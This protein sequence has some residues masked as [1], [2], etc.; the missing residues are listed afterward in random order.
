MYEVGY[1]ACRAG[2]RR[3]GLS[4][5]TVLIFLAAANIAAANWQTTPSIAVG[6]LYDDNVRLNSDIP[7]LD[8][9]EDGYAVE[10]DV[11]FAFI[12]QLTSFSLTPKIAL[13]RFSGD[14]SL[15]STDEYVNFDLFRR[16]EKSRFR[17]RGGYS[18][19][20]IRRAERL[21]AD[22]DADELIDVPDDDSGV[23]LSNEDRQ[24]I[25]L[26]PEFSHQF[27]Q[28]SLAGLRFIY[29][30]T[31]FDAAANVGLRDFTE[32][33]VELFYEHTLSQRD[34]IL[35]GVQGRR[36]EPDVGG[37]DITG[38]E[39]AIGFRRALSERTRFQINLGVDSTEDDLGNDEENVVGDVSITHRLQTTNILAAYRRS[40]R[41]SGLG[42]VSIRDTL[43]F[44]MRRDL[45]ERSAVGLGIRAY[46]RDTISVGN[47]GVVEQ[48]YLQLR[49]NYTWRL[50]RS[51]SI[52]VDYRYTDLDRGDATGSEDANRINLWFRY[53]PPVRR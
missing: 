44:N 53:R 23:V 49:A 47:Q 7:G 37:S 6:V 36:Y 52:D 10:A 15:D 46:Q 45:S 40:V 14:S 3:N 42:T 30:D 9:S 11:E 26:I 21:D 38:Y 12:T 31:S 51:M 24:R 1:R 35:F 33:R 18:Q 34:A 50:S 32:N 28:Q 13:E 17:F 48:D 4:L 5:L 29:L 8:D 22:L 25:R 41:G 16:G 27:T 20:T 39:A 19:E 43:I 2:T